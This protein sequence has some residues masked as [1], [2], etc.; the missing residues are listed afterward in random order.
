MADPIFHLLFPP[1]E[2]L[3]YSRD[4]L[5][6]VETPE[7]DSRDQAVS[8]VARKL[9]NLALN[10]GAAVLTASQMNEAG[11][12]RESR[13][14]DHHAEA[15]INI[16]DDRITVE[17]NRRGSRSGGVNVTLRGELG[18]FEESAPI[19]QLEQET[20]ETIRREVA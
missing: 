20:T 8:E 13:A 3:R 2:A 17:K 12:L 5:Q 4:Y 1:G 18:R 7:A 9:E 19:A 6:L 16:A 15:I 10:C 11:Q 14:I